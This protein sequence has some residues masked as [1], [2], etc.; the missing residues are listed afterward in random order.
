MAEVRRNL[1]LRREYLYRKSLEGREKDEYERKK[2]VREALREGKQIPTELLGEADHLRDEVNAEDDVTAEQQTHI[3][4]EYAQAGIRDPKICVTTARDPSS[5]LKQFSKEVRLIFP[6]SQ[7]INR[8]STKLGELV[9]VCRRN[10]FTDIVVV[11]EHRG[12]PDGLIISHLPYGPTVYFTILNTV[13]RHD[14]EDRGT[15]SEAYPHLIFNGFSSKL[16]DRLQNILKYLFPVPKDDSKRVITF[17]NEN[18]FISFRH[19]NYTKDGRD[20]N[21][22]EIGPRFELRPYQIRLGTLE[23]ETA[24]NE[25]VFKPYA[26]TSKKRRLL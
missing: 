26:N 1:R 5:R 14:I 11:Q 22:E 13:M 8:G 21:L 25:W 2:R 6:N 4:D 20:I 23:Q 19:H 15:I 10:D 3:D 18:D 16:G 17:S 9:D 7:R 12:E 24:E